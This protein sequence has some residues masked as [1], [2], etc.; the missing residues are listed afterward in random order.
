VTSARAA[1]YTPAA[2]TFSSPDRIAMTLTR[3]SI[4]ARRAAL[5]ARVLL[6]LLLVCAT[7][8]P[9]VAQQ[10]PPIRALY[11]TGG[12]FHDFVAQEQIVPP[13]I[14]ARTNIVWTVDHS[15]G[16]STEML[17]PRHQTTAWADS[18]DVVVYN[19]SFSHVVDPQWIERLAH[20]HRDKGV[21]AVI[22]HGATH[23]YRRSTTNAWKEL[24][25]AASM[26]HDA[27]REF[28]LE[29]MAA[30]NPIVKSLPKDWGPGSDEL[31]NIDRTWPTATPLLQAWSTEGEKHHPIAWTNTHGKAKV[32]VTTMG[33]TNRT[34]SD[35]VYLDL[36]TR[37]LLWTVG[38]LAPDGTPVAGYG[39]RAATP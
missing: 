21:A 14:A 12:G 24:M 25:G 36:V 16:K 32:F 20:A 22:L 38:K 19:M 5:C 3:P 9:A 33:H 34:M 6:P 30:D 7:A 35:P 37:G 2:A 1:S 8:S 27:Q 11:V 15:A 29:R 39:P 18:F 23:S 4:P 31:Y 26:R 28:R 17:I 13:G 10:A